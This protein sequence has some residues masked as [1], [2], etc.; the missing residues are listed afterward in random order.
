MVGDVFMALSRNYMMKQLLF[1]MKGMK[2]LFIG[3]RL[4]SGML[5]N[6]Y[7]QYKVKSVHPTIVKVYIFFFFFQ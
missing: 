6:V 5:F 7:S 1:M 3:T 2:I 4:L